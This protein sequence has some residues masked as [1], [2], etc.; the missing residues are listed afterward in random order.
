VNETYVCDLH[1]YTLQVGTLVLQVA[2]P[3]PP[4]PQFSAL[5]KTAYPPKGEVPVFPS[6]KAFN[7]PPDVTLDAD[8]F[9]KYIS[10]GLE[11]PP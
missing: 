6:V 10:R 4:S 3:D 1:F 2:R 8:S 11:V 9:V 7:W 5:A